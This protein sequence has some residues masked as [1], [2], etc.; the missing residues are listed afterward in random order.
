MVS[1][2][3][4]HRFD[5]GRAAE[6]RPRSNFVKTAI[7]V[8]LADPDAV[9]TIRAPFGPEVMRGEFYAVAS[10]D[11]SYG[12]ARTEFEGS[13]I[14]VEPH[15]WVKRSTMLAYRTAESCRVETWLSDGTHEATVD[16]KPGDWIVRH[17]GGEVTVVKP[18]TFAARYETNG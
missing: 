8:R 17:P 14:E 3:H 13:H 7:L 16:A 11:G 9:V 5:D 18:H 1:E 2:V 15:R 12:A 6:Y 4:L 10:E